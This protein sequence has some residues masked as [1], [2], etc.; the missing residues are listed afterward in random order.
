MVAHDGLSD[1]VVVGVIVTLEDKSYFDSGSPLSINGS[2]SPPTT[3]TIATITTT[4]PAGTPVSCPRHGGPMDGLFW[5]DSWH[6]Q[7]D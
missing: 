5:N 7:N 3:T 1:N 2:P 4:T 6:N